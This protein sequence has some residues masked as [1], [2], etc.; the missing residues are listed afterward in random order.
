R[1]TTRARAPDEAD[2]LGRRQ[3]RGAAG[4]Q[5]LA[6]PL[7][8]RDLADRAAD[9]R[10]IDRWPRPGLVDGCGHE[11]LRESTRTADREQASSGPNDGSPPI[12]PAIRT[13]RT[14]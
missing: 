11:D 9:R 4:R 13:S 7:I 12:P 3:P 10:A 1:A 6:R 2:Q 5:P 14:Q 8:G